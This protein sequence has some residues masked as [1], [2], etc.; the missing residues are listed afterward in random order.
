MYSTAVH[1]LDKR[2]QINSLYYHIAHA[3]TQLEV[4]LPWLPKCWRSG[5]STK[6]VGDINASEQVPCLG[7]HGV[8]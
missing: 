5:I 3:S 7:S 4:F 1:L 8:R 2:L 6:L